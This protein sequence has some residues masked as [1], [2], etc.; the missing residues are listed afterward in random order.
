MIIDKLFKNEF[1]RNK[2]RIGKKKS[3]FTF[4]DVYKQF[5]K[6]LIINGVN[7][8]TREIVYF[9]RLTHPNMEVAVACRIS[10]GLPLIFKAYNYE[11]D[12]YI[13][14]GVVDSYPIRYCTTRIFEMLDSCNEYTKNDIKNAVSES[15]DLI[16]DDTNTELIEKTIGIK[17]YDN[18][19]FN[20]VENG[21]SDRIEEFTF[22]LYIKEVIGLVMDQGAKHYIDSHLWNKTVK[23]NMGDK[24]VANFDLSKKDIQDLIDLGIS[25]SNN[26][27]NTKILE[28]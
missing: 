5:G 4:D 27:V 1:K 24:S 8:N 23:L 10:S 9:N 20:Y 15:I 26:Y 25:A 22:S 14:G 21:R 16:R 18:R 6:N 17:G 2:S 28:N 7:V 12:Y 11:G 19:T 3:G 13:D